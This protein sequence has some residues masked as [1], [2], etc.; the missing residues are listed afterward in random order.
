MSLIVARKDGRKIG[1]VSDTKLTYPNHET[2]NLKTSPIDGVVKTVILN[3][4]L[5]VSF[6]GEIEPAE[7][8][9]KE[10]NISTDT[11]SILH[12]LEKFHHFSKGETEFIFCI[13][14]PD[15]TIYEI[16]NGI[17]QETN[18]SWIGDK[19][20][21]ENF[22]KSILAHPTKEQRQEKVE[23]P[24]QNSKT[25]QPT[26]TITEMN[27]TFEVSQNSSIL[28][29][30]SSA[31]DNVIDNDSISSVGGFKVNVIYDN[32]FFYNGYIKNYRQNVTMTGYGSQVIGHGTAQDG[33]YSINFIGGSSD[34]KSVALHV[35]Q[36]NFGIVYTRTDYGLLKP[37][38]LNFDEVDFSDEIQDKY[39]IISSFST[40]DR[41]QK[42]VTKA[43]NFF[44]QKN[45]R[46]SE[47]YF[48]KGFNSANAAEKAKF[49]FSKGL[50]LLSLDD[51]R[52]AMKAFSE[53]IK[54]DPTYTTRILNV[55]HPKR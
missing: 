27:L 40:Q 22:Q 8:A 42:Y 31:M 9:L 43:G 20:V 3:E 30:L 11:N 48:D 51:K 5:C 46:Q 36:G 19:A 13:G 25:N 35:S 24:L 54:I 34:F 7:L 18:Q 50:L 32:K 16:K 38:I 14:K 53:T 39:N 10:I 26:I 4:N 28:S 29:K 44:H 21:F 12:L 33:S 17:V 37:V 55:L 23:T 15:L 41:V 6:A 2:K 47:V 49:L 52:P 1:I 45:Y